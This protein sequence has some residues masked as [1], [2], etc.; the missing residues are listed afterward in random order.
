VP[1]F[2]AFAMWVITQTAQTAQTA[3]ITQHAT[4]KMADIFAFT[5]SIKKQIVLK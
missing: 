1:N 4:D 3:K 2:G 5:S